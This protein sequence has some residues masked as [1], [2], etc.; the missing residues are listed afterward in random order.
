MQSKLYILST[1]SNNM[2]YVLAGSIYSSQVDRPEQRGMLAL[3]KGD[4]IL[5]YDMNN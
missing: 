1:K 4:I 2:R 3:N 5:L